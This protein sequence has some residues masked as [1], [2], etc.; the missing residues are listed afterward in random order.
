[1]RF[2]SAMHMKNNGPEI[3]VC[4]S[5]ITV[6]LNFTHYNLLYVHTRDGSET[7]NG[8][9]T[10]QKYQNFQKMCKKE[11]KITFFDPLTI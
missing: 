4:V 5:K 2:L 1:M 3:N 9:C 11:K 8:V 7:L 6:Q 10:R